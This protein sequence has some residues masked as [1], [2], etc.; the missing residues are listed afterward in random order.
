[1]S[2]M[3]HEQTSRHVRVMS[4]LPPIVLRKAV[5]SV[6]YATIESKKA[7][8][9]NQSCAANRVLESKLRLT[10][11]GTSKSAFWL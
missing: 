9:L 5:A 10:L 2:A 8:L 6:E 4:A 11:G 3:G 1:M 7:C